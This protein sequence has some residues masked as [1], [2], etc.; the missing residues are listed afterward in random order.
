MMKKLFFI[1]IIAVF[2]YNFSKLQE[3]KSLGQ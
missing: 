3:S 1:D 2:N